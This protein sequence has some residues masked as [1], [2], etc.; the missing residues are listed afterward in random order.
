MEAP[1]F[2]PE[3]FLNRFDSLMHGVDAVICNHVSNVFG[4]ILPIELIAMLCR[5]RGIPL[6][7]DASQSAGTIPINAAAL[8]AF[9][10]AMPGHKGLYDRRDA[11]LL[12][13]DT[14]GKPL[15]EVAPQSSAQMNMPNFLP[16]PEAGTHN[17]RASPVFWKE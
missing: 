8:G 10:I 4:Y 7:I 17:V 11:L 16:T 12:C 13:G 15:L 1:L 2:S 14:T 9:F 6:I 3:L 5:M